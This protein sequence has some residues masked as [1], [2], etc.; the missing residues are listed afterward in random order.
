MSLLSGCLKPYINYE[1]VWNICIFKMY[2]FY[3]TAGYTLYRSVNIC[4]VDQS[5]FSGVI[6]NRNT[7]TVKSGQLVY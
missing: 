1:T 2:F 5:Q 3:H 6:A 7:F 4:I